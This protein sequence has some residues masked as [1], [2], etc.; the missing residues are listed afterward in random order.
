MVFVFVLRFEK[1][2]LTNRGQV[3]G[4]VLILYVKSLLGI[5]WI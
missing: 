4:S 2:K 3:N 5:V 1:H